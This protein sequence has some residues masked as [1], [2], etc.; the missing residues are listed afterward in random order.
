[1]PLLLP[2][3]ASSPNGKGLRI[4]RS[5]GGT[6]GM[7]TIED[8]FATGSVTVAFA[9]L[10]R[11]R[12]LV[13]AVGGASMLPDIIRGQFL[14]WGIFARGYS[15]EDGGRRCSY[16]PKATL[17]VKAS[18]TKWACSITAPKMTAVDVTCQCL[19]TRQSRRQ[20][21]TVKANPTKW[22]CST[23]APK[24]AAVD[25]TRHWMRSWGSQ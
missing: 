11:D 4:L 17:A 22:T 3:C 24:M 25:V 14:A 12:V 6:T 20:P 16:E 23:T 2:S 9:L 10:V 18:P 7:S 13:G 8:N 21:F 15:A 1:M 5:E 19:A